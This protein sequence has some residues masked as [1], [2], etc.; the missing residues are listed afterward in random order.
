MRT[1]QT[2]RRFFSVLITVSMFLTCIPI[3]KLV[4]ADNEPT[5]Y[6]IFDLTP[7]NEN[8]AAFKIRTSSD[9]PGDGSSW[10]AMYIDGANGTANAFDA[11]GLDPRTE[12]VLNNANVFNASIYQDFKLLGHSRIDY[13]GGQAYTSSNTDCCFEFLADELLSGNRPYDR[14]TYRRKPDAQYAH[15]LFLSGDRS[16]RYLNDPA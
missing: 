6:Y 5:I 9:D 10:V 12:L 15:G 2:I 13:E 1:H 11:T 4:I 3:A 16:K 14:Y 8:D 7:E